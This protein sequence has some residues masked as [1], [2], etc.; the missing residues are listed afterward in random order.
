MPLLPRVVVAL[1]VRAAE[2]DGAVRL[3][4]L[5]QA[6]HEDVEAQGVVEGLGVLAV[7]ALVDRRLL[8]RREGRG[9]LDRFRPSGGRV[10][11]G[12][13]AEA[14]SL[15]RLASTLSGGASG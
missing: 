3:I 4:V 5:V 6:L 12:G 1:G 11:A 7:D 15:V 8:R 2:P 13:V 10:E 14:G 9:R